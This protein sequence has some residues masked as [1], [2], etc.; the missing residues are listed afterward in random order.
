MNQKVFTRRVYITGVLVLSIACFFI[1]R[2]LVLHLSNKIIFEEPRANE[3]KR[4]YIKDKNGYII[5]ISVEQESLSANPG[6]I[7]KPQETAAKIAPVVNLTADYIYSQFKKK[8]Q[9]VWIKRK[10]DSE[11]AKRVRELSIRG[12]YLKKE[13]HRLYPHG[14]L[15]SN[16]V[17]FTGID[18][19]GL[20]GIEYKYEDVLTG[21]KGGLHLGDERDAIK[22]FNVVLTIDHNIQFISEREIE[23]GVKRSGSRRGVALVFEIKTG[24]VLALA[25]FP[26]FDPNKY[27]GYSDEARKCYSVVDS[28]EPGSTLK[29]FAMASLLEAHPDVLNES[30]LCKGKID[31]SDITINCTGV[32]GVLSPDGIIRHSCNAG[33]IQA[34]KRVSKENFYNMLHRLGFGQNTGIELPA[35]S[36]GLLRNLKDWSGVSKYSIALGQEMSVTSIQIAAAYGA[37][38][39]DG[40]YMAPAII[41]AIEK[42]DGARI[43]SFFPKSKGRVINKDIAARILKMMRSVVLDGT[44]QKASLVF[45]DAAGKTGTAQKSMNKGG[46]SPDKFIASF[47][48][49]APYNNPELCILV[50]MDEPVSITYGGEAAAPVFAKIADRVLPYYGVKSKAVPAREP[51]QIRSAPLKITN[52]KRMPDFRNLSFQESIQALVILQRSADISYAFEGTGRVYKQT[53]EP[54]SSL[55]GN[56]QKIILYLREQ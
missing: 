53:P 1:Y 7:E 20:A 23:N 8:K 26:N 35:E 22:G 43:R 38:A 11:T 17:G 10:L 13:F 14:R 40:V 36:E 49:I 19:N 9:F 41:E 4:G 44:G 48:G 37:L 15:A 27:M 5:A 33:M 21:K 56:Q 12:L 50:V 29:I 54:G 24:R 3:V 32:H 31:V 18:N 47:I 39:N 46:Y 55:A 51:L 45:Y 2:L 28:F 16:I 6:E 30:F 52:T 42:D 34:M 25:Q